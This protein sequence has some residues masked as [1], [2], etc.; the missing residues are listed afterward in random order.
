M[1]LFLVNKCCYKLKNFLS[2]IINTPKP[3]AIPPQS[4]V[5]PLSQKKTQTRREEMKET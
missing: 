2:K 3:P 5:E 1:I 4:Q